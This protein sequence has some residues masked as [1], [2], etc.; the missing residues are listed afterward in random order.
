MKKLLLVLAFAVCT[1]TA[2]AQFNVGATIGLPSGDAGDITT[3]SFSV[4]ANYMMPTDNSVSYG[5]AA[6]YLYYSGDDPFPNWSFLPLAGVVRFEASESFSLGA[7]IGYAIGLNPVVSN[8][9][10][11]LSNFYI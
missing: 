5:F 8:L 3:L 4:D 9:T 10:Q 2:N 11:P 1:L 7:D 6:S